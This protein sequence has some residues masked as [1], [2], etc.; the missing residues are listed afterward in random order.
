MIGWLCNLVKS[1]YFKSHIAEPIY[2]TTERNTE[3]GSKGQPE[4]E[5]GQK[6]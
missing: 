2:K 6:A 4:R 1:F 5:R 3:N